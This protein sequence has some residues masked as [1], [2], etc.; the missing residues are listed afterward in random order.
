MAEQLWTVRLST[1]RDDTE[2][3]DPIVE[4]RTKVPGGDLMERI[5]EMSEKVVDHD[6]Y[7]MIMLAD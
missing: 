3:E 7:L 4:E 1:F 6:H 2:D 5:L